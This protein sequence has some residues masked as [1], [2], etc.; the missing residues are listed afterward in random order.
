MG[1][2][3]TGSQPGVMVGNP[4]YRPRRNSRQPNSMRP[5]LSGRD[6]RR[7]PADSK[8]DHD[9]ASEIRHDSAPQQSSHSLKASL[10]QKPERETRAVGPITARRCVQ[11]IRETIHDCEC[12]DSRKNAEPIPSDLVAIIHPGHFMN[13]RN[14]AVRVRKRGAP[15]V[16]VLLLRAEARI[17]QNRRVAVST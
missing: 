6:I 16:S 9:D 2:S 11:R 12:H 4:T 3:R 17:Q 5:P 14:I 1:R 15:K 8:S 13:K 10:F 7:H